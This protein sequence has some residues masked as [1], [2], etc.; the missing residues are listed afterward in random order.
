MALG[1]N[2]MLLSIG[3]IFSFHTSDVWK[4]LI[5]FRFSQNAT[6]REISLRYVCIYLI[7][8]AYISIESD[9]SLIALF[10][11]FSHFP[12]SVSGTWRQV[13]PQMQH[14]RNQWHHGHRSN[15]QLMGCF[16]FP[17]IIQ[18]K[19]HNWY[20]KTRYRI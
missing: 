2:Q 13:H 19:Y 20:I 9:G 1:I 3:L 17:Q 18:S 7:W 4:L 6:Q 8:K 11:S 12:F 15:A 16:A 5:T 10:T 14:L